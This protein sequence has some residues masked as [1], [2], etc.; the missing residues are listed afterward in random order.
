M[1]VIYYGVMS[2]VISGVRAIPELVVPM[3]NEREKQTYYGALDYS[4]H[5]F[6]VQA[7]PQGQG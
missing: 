3:V 2:V 6:L 1:S 4:N 7:Y 5:K